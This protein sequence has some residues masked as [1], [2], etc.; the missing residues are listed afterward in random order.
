MLLPCCGMVHIKDPLLL[1]GRSSPSFSIIIITIRLLNQKQ[2]PFAYSAQIN[3]A[4]RE[5][6]AAKLIP[7]NVLQ[8]RQQGIHLE[9]G[10]RSI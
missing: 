10:A 2:P 8:S 5:Q 1:V 4:G 9:L 6:H 7:G 3:V